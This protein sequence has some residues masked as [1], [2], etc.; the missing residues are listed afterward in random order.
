[1]LRKLFKFL[2]YT[3]LF[4][5]FAAAMAAVVI[6]MQWPWW[7]GAALAA[8]L[9]SLFF[10]LL[11]LKRYLLRLRERKFVQQVIAQ[12]RSAIGQ[13]PPHERRHLQEMQEKWK[14]AVDLLRQSNLKKK[15][16][17]LY[18]LP[19]YMVL[20]ESGS[21]KTTAIKNARASAPVSEV[22]AGLAGTRN[23][24]WWFFDEAIILDTAGRYSVAVD[25]EPD[26]EE[27][28][29]FLTL[30]ARYRKKE[31]L[32]GVI[33]T[34]GADHLLGKSADELRENGLSL[35][36]RTDQLMRVCGAKFPVYLMVTKIDRVHGFNPF[37]QMLPEDRMNQAMG[38]SAEEPSESW[39]TF[40]AAA[41]RL[42]C[43]RLKD[44]RLLIIQG[45]PRVD[46]GVLLFPDEFNRLYAGLKAFAEGAFQENPYQET[47]MFTGVYYS[48]GKQGDKPCSEFVQHFN[49]PAAAPDKPRNGIFL[50]DFFKKIL[51]GDRDLFLP[52][53]EFFRW[54][55]VTKRF[56]LT[57][58]CLLW[59]FLLGIV[60]FSYFKNIDTVEA[61]RKNVGSLPVVTGELS[62]D[63]L[64][65]SDYARKLENARQH[66]RNWIIPRF[67]FDHSLQVEQ[68]YID[69]YTDY[70]R[71]NLLLPMDWQL[72]ENVPLLDTDTADETIADYASHIAARMAILQDHL[73]E[74]GNLQ[75]PQ[76]LSGIS[77]EILRVVDPGM[78]GEIA[79]R[80][81]QS[82]YQYLELHTARQ[83]IENRRERLDAYLVQVLEAKDMN[84]DW[85]VRKTFPGASPVGLEDFWGKLENQGQTAR[86]P[87]VDAA[88]TRGGKARIEAFIDR[89]ENVLGP[90]QRFAAARADFQKRY[91]NNY[92]QEW[93]NFAV[94]FPEGL[95][96]LTSEQQR[97]SI[98][99]SMTT[100]NNPYFSLL[101]EMAR[102]LQVIDDL[103]LW[104]HM[105]PELEEIRNTRTGLEEEDPSL[106]DRIRRRS[107]AAERK[108]TA[109]TS[110]EAARRK[111]KRLAAAETWQAY[112]SALR[113]LAAVTGAPETAYEMAKEF[114][115]G[116][117]SASQE[118]SPFFETRDHLTFL[119]GLL[120][121]DGDLSVA[122]A[123]IE[124]PLDYL[125]WFATREAGKVVQRKW[126]ET[127][128]AD[129][130]GVDPYKV[131][132]R[133]FNRQDG[134][135][136]KFI[137][138]PAEPFLRRG[139]DGF[140]ARRS[141][142]QSVSFASEFFT[143][144][145]KGADGT[146]DMKDQYSVGISTL[147]I[148]INEGAEFFPRA[149]ILNLA[150]DEGPLQLENYNFRRSA[151]FDWRMEEC[152]EVGLTILL[153]DTRL[154]YTY[155]G[156][157]GF[158]RFLEDFR[159]GFREFTPED[160]PE[161]SE[162]LK[163]R[164]VAW[165]R[166]SYQLKNARPVI[167]L[168]KDVPREVPGKIVNSR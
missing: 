92:L 65:L 67:G 91:E 28:E 100:D 158:A 54:R 77:T 48:S 116:D 57:A 168:L 83:D 160:F 16:N 108:V 10:G 167:D 142:G 63:L 138:G 146:V 134:A 9:L 78:V 43:N 62:T 31:P 51:P 66:N 111:E 137:D 26:R 107:D 27:W 40:L 154:S 141:L 76:N 84:L 85:V 61:F 82:Y 39:E 60:S 12:D 21:G 8:G 114:F 50:R 17:P 153:P 70:F 45:T 56:G 117:P 5:A 165:I 2:L 166:I 18:V 15:G 53:A 69:R 127:V 46:P 4:V 1:M 34:V 89:M 96:L 123:L 119:T 118:E 147:P 140:H 109:V 6:L 79:V 42:V 143:F 144:L 23:F 105:F 161:Q 95:Y 32:N 25:E 72:R 102:Q 22:S 112:V 145:D 11:F 90:S 13:V 37:S 52:I 128:L 139:K 156:D 150:C 41:H 110:P 74:G 29:K 24:D 152:G 55:R 101:S 49:I 149:V 38:Y 162:L 33:L 132:Y 99:G 125:A 71:N 121:E 155:E 58:W 135:A 97:K 120:E 47:P 88:Y 122:E 86:Y 148:R 130:R 20:G 124:G 80:F 81:G 7:V 35:R 87:S 19:W 98:A 159:H 126:E 133:V 131:P 73:E 103:P 115:S 68:H 36:K 157:M 136:W 59:F 64:L 104:A 93:A 106:V 151:Q 3:V 30:V 94:N 129:V 44:L 113:S 163:N 14:K 75:A 164:G